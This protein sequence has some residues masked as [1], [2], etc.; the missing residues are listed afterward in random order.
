MELYM[1]HTEL[2]PETPLYFAEYVTQ[3]EETVARLEAKV[4]AVEDFRKSLPYSVV[5][6]RNGLL[7]ALDSA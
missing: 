7:D 5:H 4:S 1:S 6:I 3:L 2:P